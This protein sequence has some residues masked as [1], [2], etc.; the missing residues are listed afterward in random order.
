[1][2]SCC[3][4]LVPQEACVCDEREELK[5]AVKRLADL[6][7]KLSSSSRKDQEKQEVEVS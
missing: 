7:Q 2:G 4:L 1:M 6:A 5:E 3:S